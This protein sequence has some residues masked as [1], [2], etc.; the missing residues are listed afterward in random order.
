MLRYLPENVSTFGARIDSLFHL[1][2]AITGVIFV[3]VFVTLLVF[4]FLYRERAGVRATYTHGSKTLEVIWTVVPAVI[5]VV[6]TVLSASAWRDIKMT[7][8]EADVRVRVIG[9]QFNWRMI[10]PGPDRIFDTQ[11]DL[12]LANELHVPVNKN[13]VVSLQSEDVIHSLFLPNLRVKQDALPGRTIEVWF[14]VYKAGR[15]EIACAELCGFGHYNM[16]GWLTV[17]TPEDYRRWQD[18][19]WPATSTARLKESA[20]GSESPIHGGGAR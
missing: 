1:I 17:H 3:L 6:L 11:D 16:R 20:P 10:Y 2:Y 15:Y 14:N 7:V 18:E 5:L 13:V 4:L 19:T 12:E 8:P 9:K